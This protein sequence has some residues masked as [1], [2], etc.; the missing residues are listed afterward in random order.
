MRVL[1]LSSWF[2]YPPDNGSKLRV[3]HLLKALRE[4]HDVTLLSFSFEASSLGDAN[5]PEYPQEQTEII[6]RNPFERGSLVRKL[7]FLSPVPVVN[8]PL[9]EMTQ[10]VRDTLAQ[11]IFDVVIASTGVMAAYALDTPPE[12]VKV[13]EEHNSLTRWMRERYRGQ[14]SVTRR[15]QN[16]A[17]WQKTRHYEARL[18]NRFD[19]CIMVS[20]QDR[21]TCL[22]DLPGYKGSI[23]VIPN[24]VD[25]QH[26]HPGIAPAKS[27]RLIYNGA[28]T[29]FANYDAVRFFLTEVY[30]IVRQRVPNV[31]LTIT[32]ST[33]GVDLSGLDLDKSVI[34]SGY[35]DDIRFP[36]A[37][38]TVC[39]VPLRQGGGTRLKI[40][41]AMAL[42]TPVVA[43][44]KGAEGLD[45][46]P[47]HDILI[48]DE[49]AEFARQVVRLL[50]DA[51][52]ARQLADNARRLV[53]RS[54]DWD[55]IGKRFVRLVESVVES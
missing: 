12:T 17:S 55:Q 49:P 16:W 52:L 18:L 34:L 29:Y 32:G 23:E 27:G 28:L 33:S 20:E 47:D 24:G 36:V 41:E 13:I 31:S 2:P 39:V 48:A 19:L 45:V 53:E 3:Y 1:F 7:R 35:V 43:T 6:H 26:N 46:T 22:H 21:A 51:S 25:C 14:S 38:A 50:G 10:A 40:L 4:R 8:L 54:Y 9:R 15:L 30:P 37:E 44:S 42:G 5:S 11:T